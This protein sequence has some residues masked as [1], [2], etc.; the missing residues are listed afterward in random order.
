MKKRID[1]YLG[2]RE[3]GSCQEIVVCKR[4]SKLE[5]KNPK[6]RGL[7]LDLVLS[8]TATSHAPMLIQIQNSLIL[9]RR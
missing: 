8:T 6:E 9:L 3:Q 2:G 5:E 4:G 1:T 7:D